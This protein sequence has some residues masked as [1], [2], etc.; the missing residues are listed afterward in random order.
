[1]WVRIGPVA[2]GRSVYSW[3]WI[4]M[5]RVFKRLAAFHQAARIP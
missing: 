5:G 3:S 4:V 2:V 1:M